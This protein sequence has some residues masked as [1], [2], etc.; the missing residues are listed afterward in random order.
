MGINNL[1]RK[2]N[3]INNINYLIKSREET[4]ASLSNR[5]GVT[6]STI[7]NILDGKVKS[8]QNSTIERIAEH[9]GTTCYII[10]NND[11]EEIERK[12]QTV[13]IDG[14]KNP[15]AIPVIDE[16]EFFTTINKTIGELVVK[17]PIT[18]LFKIDTNIVAL[19]VGSQLSD[20]YNINNILIIKRFAVPVHDELKL[21]LTENNKLTIRRSKDYI[22]DTEKLIGI[23]IEERIQ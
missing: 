18:Y 21:L 9:F 20:L 3:V 2:T 19:K 15:T 4:R 16:D 13:A 5:T 23:I 17:Y 6:R 14:N 8:V 7:Y 12:E 10:E 1:K 22:N 11:I